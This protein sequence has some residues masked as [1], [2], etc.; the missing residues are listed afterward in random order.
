VTNYIKLR[1]YYEK[2]GYQFIT[3]NDSEV[4]AV[5]LVDEM[6]KGASLKEAMTA[7]VHDLDGSFSYIAVTP[8]AVG[9]AKEPFSMKPIVL[10]ET[11]DF[12]AFASESLAITNGFG[13]SLPVREPGAEE[14]LVWNL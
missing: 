3:G 8:T 14:V 7:S 1:A 2:K 11:D 4:I 13:E 5:Y 12:I 10:A 9:L 6:K